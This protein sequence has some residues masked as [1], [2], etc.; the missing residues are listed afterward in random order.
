MKCNATFEWFAELT[1][2]FENWQYN[3]LMAGGNA[4]ALVVMKLGGFYKFLPNGEAGS[5]KRGIKRSL[6]R[7]CGLESQAPV[8]IVFLISFESMYHL[9]VFR[10]SRKVAKKWE[11]EIVLINKMAI[12]LDRRIASRQTKRDH[13]LLP[14]EAWRWHWGNVKLESWGPQDY[15]I[16][17]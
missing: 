3:K 8:H 14:K 9:L 12:I 10:M 15:T 16:L 7:S 2:V 1:G 13:A 5:G 4:K 11:C 17:K 6:D